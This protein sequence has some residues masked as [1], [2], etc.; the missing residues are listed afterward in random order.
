MPLHLYCMIHNAL[1][2]HIYTDLNHIFKMH[3][4]EATIRL[5]QL[6]CKNKNTVSKNVTSS[7]LFTVLEHGLAIYRSYFARPRKTFAEYNLKICNHQV[8]QRQ[9]CYYHQHKS[10]KK[11]IINSWMQGQGDN[12]RIWCPHNLRLFESDGRG[13]WAVGR[14]VCVGIFVTVICLRASLLW[15]HL[16]CV[17]PKLCVYA[18]MQACVGV[19]VGA[20]VFYEYVC[21]SMWCLYK[22]SM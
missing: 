18:Y 10:K 14:Y 3:S 12:F 7:R 13:K 9:K 19:G 16:V 21:V 17:E 5:V 1:N 22:F 11:K 8:L 6:L 20:W 2:K 4:H 15:Q